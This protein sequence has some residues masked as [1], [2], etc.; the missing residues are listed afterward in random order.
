M[1]ELELDY[2]EDEC[3]EGEIV[4]A[5]SVNGGERCSNQG[6]G[7]GDHGKRGLEGGRVRAFLQALAP[8]ESR[9][10]DSCISDVG[11][12]LLQ[13]VP[14]R[15]ASL[16]DFYDEWPASHL[17]H[18]GQGGASKKKTGGNGWDMW[19]YNRGQC[20]FDFFK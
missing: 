14:E 8:S 17:P 18:L 4:E 16:I 6:W 19:S 9:E 2:E 20:W 7:K 15:T 10:R 5:R 3:E 12:C 13:E 1:A 11:K